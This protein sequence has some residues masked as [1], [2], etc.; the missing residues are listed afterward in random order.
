MKELPFKEFGLTYEGTELEDNKKLLD[1]DISYE[2]NNKILKFSD[3]PCKISI[4]NQGGVY[5][6]AHN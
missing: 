6:V 5:F 3:K 2:S 4:K 1:Y